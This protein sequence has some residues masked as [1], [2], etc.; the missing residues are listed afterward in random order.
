MYACHQVMLSCQ[1]HNHYSVAGWLY[2][3]SCSTSVRASHGLCSTAFG[4]LESSGHHFLV[5]SPLSSWE[6][7][8]V[9]WDEVPL[10]YSWTTRILPHHLIQPT[11]FPILRGIL[12]ILLH[13]LSMLTFPTHQLSVSPI[14][15]DAM[16]AFGQRVWK[17]AGNFSRTGQSSMITAL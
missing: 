1:I 14:F 7:A 4:N 2:P 15:D 16:P 11:S 12:L 8:T 13:P 6:A 10:I 9:T 5:Y 17:V 3:S